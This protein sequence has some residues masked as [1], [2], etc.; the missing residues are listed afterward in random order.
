M[1]NQAIIIGSGI[2]GLAASIRLANK[3]YQV[4]VFEAN[5]YPGG[6]LSEINLDGY[7]FDAG[8][9]LFTLPEQVDE[10]FTLSGKNPSDY[11]KYQKLPVN[12]RYFWEDGTRITAHADIDA[13]AKEVHTKL[14]ENP[15]NIRRAL[16]QSSY[17][18]RYLSPLFM[19]RS[20]HQGSTW[21]NKNALKAYLRLGK[22][23]L[24]QTMHRSNSKQFD[25]PKLVQL[26]DRYATYNGSNPYQTPATLTIIPHLEFNRGAYFPEEGMHSITQSL[27]SLARDLGV[28]F[29][30]NQKVERILVENNR[31]KGVL[32]QGKVHKAA[33]LVNNMDM[34]NA[35]KTL[36][37]DQ[38]QPKR[39]LQQPKSSS[40]LIFYWGIKKVF[41]ELDLH[42]IFFSDDYQEEFAYI[43]SKKSIYSDPTVYI[44]ITSVYKKDDAPENCMNWFTMINVPNNQGQNWEVLKSQARAAIIGKINR[45]LGT[46]IGPLIAVE[47]VLEPITIESKTSSANGALYGNSS[48]NRYAAFLRHANFSSID[49]LYFCGGSVHPGGGI[50]L[51][52]L[53]A[54]I[55]AGMIPDA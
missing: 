52:L 47:E 44:N 49:G 22:F 35:Y 23:G 12:C 51:C 19:Q 13:F 45:I 6:K 9:S 24:F 4:Q 50:P 2:A 26:F 43:F 36:L 28:T 30:F 55:T 54:K 40:A 21:F 42:N 31:A 29:H 32:V 25:H 10:L 11:F 14:G 1:N 38:R 5:A 34:V 48:N 8:P 7:R 27:Y 18:Y 15:K 33:L 20:L 37:K 39:L 16:N 17:I 41:P 3:G 46:D 53:S